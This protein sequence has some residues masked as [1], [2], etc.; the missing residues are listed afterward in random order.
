MDSKINANT[1]TTVANRQTINTVWPLNDDIKCPGLTPEAIEI[2]RLAKELPKR[3]AIF[4]YKQSLPYFRVVFVGGTG[5]GKSTS[6]DRC[7]DVCCGHG[8]SIWN[9]LVYRSDCDFDP[10][11]D[12]FKKF[13]GYC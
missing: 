13:T 11:A 4:S 5:T 10:G 1:Q 6:Q 3:H 9:D 7:V 8:P 2:Y 12:G